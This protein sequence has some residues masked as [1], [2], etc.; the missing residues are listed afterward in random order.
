MNVCI[1]GGGLVSL[2]LAKALVNLGIYVD[3]FSNQ[4]K[5]QVNKSRTIGISKTNVDFFNKNILGIKEL[6]WD[7]D[8]IE[9]YSENLKNER[10]LN[11]ENSNKNLFSIVKNFD[12]YKSLL[13]SLKNDKLF[14]FKKKAKL[15]STE[16]Y[17][18]IINC[19]VDNLFSK[20]YFQKKLK[21]DYNS[22]AHTTIIEHK[23][24]SKNNIA[25]QIFTKKGP[26][27]FLPISEFKTSIVYSGRGSKDMDLETLIKKHNNKYSIT[28]FNKTFSFELNSVN[29]RN[30]YYENIMAFGDL[31]HKLHPLAGQGFNMSVR[32][33]KSLVELIRFRLDHG[34]DL[35]ISICRNFEIKTRHKNYLFSSG[36][37]FVYEFFNL[38]SK[39]DNSILSK[40]VQFLGKNKYANKFF[41]KL[42]DNG[43]VI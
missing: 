5:N 6:L 21:K 13:S 7:I 41:T 18:L 19:D 26:L 35:D 40:S 23:R 22:Y 39:M 36:V 4:K 16:D 38:E 34:L 25:T 42:A 43:V 10:I 12:L 15:I 31:L 20:K 32:D 17:K 9:I 28:K 3:F 37:D 24:I 29:L 30:Y 1:I 2:T 14:I 33:I 8:K 11:F 27:A